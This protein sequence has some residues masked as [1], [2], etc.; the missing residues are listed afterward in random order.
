MNATLAN[1]IFFVILGI[2]LAVALYWLRKVRA[3][4]MPVTFKNLDEETTIYQVARWAAKQLDLPP[5]DSRLRWSLV[6]WA[7]S[8]NFSWM[9]R[10]PK[11]E[12][13][14]LQPFIDLVIEGKGPPQNLPAEYND[15]RP[16]ILRGFKARMKAESLWPN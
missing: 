15:L 12:L 13:A 4:E 6:L 10:I 11:S 16:G 3:A 14:E 2:G 8:A 5:G 7:S 1:F 9:G